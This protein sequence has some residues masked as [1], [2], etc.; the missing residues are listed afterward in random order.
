MIRAKLYITQHGETLFNQLNKVQG[1]SDSPLSS[2][3]SEDA[4]MLGRCLRHI[5]F[6]KIYCSDSKR[7][8]DTAYLIK[9]SALFNVPVISDPRLREWCYGSFE[10]EPYKKLNRLL[11]SAL[12]TNDI[13]SLNLRIPQICQII[14]DADTSGWTED[15]TTIEKKL[16]SL[17]HDIA[18]DST[19][20][21]CNILII[22]HACTIKTL[23]FLYGRNFLN[24]T[25]Q[26]DYLSIST[27]I[28]DNGTLHFEEVNNTYI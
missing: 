25:N 26:I 20:K 22:S 8:F 14:K 23:I 10:G 9:K 19:E 21:Y 6:N 18:R 7:A 3:G 15:F 24:S 12:S 16:K 28:Y 11:S 2:K 13:T 1:W 4:I 17:I 5:N 27:L